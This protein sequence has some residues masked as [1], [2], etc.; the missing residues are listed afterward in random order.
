M[1]SKKAAL[2]GQG[3]AHAQNQTS[4]ILVN[5]LPIEL[6]SQ[7]IEIWTKQSFAASVSK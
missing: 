6:V 2:N 7:W 3:L 5:G 1:T 4:G